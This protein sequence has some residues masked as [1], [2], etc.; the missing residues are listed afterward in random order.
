MSSDETTRHPAPVGAGFDEQISGIAVL[1]DPLRRVL[2]LHLIA[3]A[4]R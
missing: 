1:G 3:Q 2:Y 4:R